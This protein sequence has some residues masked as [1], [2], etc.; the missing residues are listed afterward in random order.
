MTVKSEN[1]WRA[2]LIISQLAFLSLTIAVIINALTW[3]ARDALYYA[4]WGA[5]IA[6][7]TMILGTIQLIIRGKRPAPWA[8]AFVLVMSAVFGYLLV[9]I[10][11]SWISII[12]EV[13]KFAT[14]PA[15]STGASVV[16]VG[17]GTLVVGML[18]FA[19]RLKWR[20]LYGASEAMVGVVVASQRFYHDAVATDTPTP[21]IVLAIL[22]AGVYLVVRGADNIHQGLTKAPFDPFGQ[23][24]I[25]GLDSLGQNR[26]WR[27]YWIVADRN[28]PNASPD[29]KRS[30]F[31]D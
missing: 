8:I 30:G 23:R 22:T 21:F 14:S 10:G 20:C 28:R 7:I 2:T 19:I 18:L 24:I 31:S 26:S 3:H 29:D 16:L 12:G 6:T 27:S 13:Y 15:F 4:D 25:R 1:L 9:L 5:L 11:Y 17:L